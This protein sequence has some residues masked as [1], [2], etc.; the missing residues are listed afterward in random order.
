MTW[1][2]HLQGVFFCHFAS[3]PFDVSFVFI[4]FLY[5]LY[6]PFCFSSV[7]FDLSGNIQ[8]YDNI[9]KPLF[10]QILLISDFVPTKSM[11]E[12]IIFLVLI[13]YF[14][15]KA[16]K[17]QNWKTV[18]YSIFEKLHKLSKLLF[19]KNSKINILWFERF[20][21]SKRAVWMTFTKLLFFPTF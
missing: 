20:E 5:V 9:I 7:N 16:E 4:N 8:Q 18:S 13:A 21:R 15:S 11:I 17:Y 19:A 10:C 2:C 12:K 1:L 14:F 6:P 3:V